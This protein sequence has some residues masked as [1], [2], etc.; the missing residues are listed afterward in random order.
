M[1]FPKDAISTSTSIDGIGSAEIISTFPSTVLGIKMQQ[2]G[3][4]SETVV[5]CN[6]GNI[7]YNYAK[8]YDLDLV[9]HICNTAVTVNKTGAGDSSFINITYV[10]YDITKTASITPNVYQGFTHGEIVLTVFAFLV[11]ITLAYKF[12]WDTTTK[13]DDA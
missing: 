11:W 8:D 4:Q 2:S 9:H 5:K 3:T 6:G 13:K 10:P 12:F 1:I 7:A